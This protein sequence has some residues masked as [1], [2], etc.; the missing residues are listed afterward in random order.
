MFIRDI[1]GIFYSAFPPFLQGPGHFMMEQWNPLGVV[2]VISAFNFPV[3][4]YG[5]NSAIGL[6][7]GNPILWKGAPTTNLCSVAV[8]KILQKVFEQN[9]LPPS[10]CSLVSG[11]VDVGKSMAKDS[12]IDLMSFTG[13][14]E[15]RL[16]G[17][18]FIPSVLILYS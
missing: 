16:G 4:V 1:E 14:T 3:A 12:R 13:S 7:C 10:I 18:N 17:L 2:G 11:G 6:V 5:W 9:N 15:V 8:T